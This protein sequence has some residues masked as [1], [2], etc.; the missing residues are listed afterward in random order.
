MAEGGEVVDLVVEVMG[1]GG[2]AMEDEDCR[3]KV[4]RA[5]GW[6]MDVVVGEVV[7]GG[8]CVGWKAFK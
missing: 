4:L 8:E 2:E 6:N 7:C 1:D 5:G 3:F